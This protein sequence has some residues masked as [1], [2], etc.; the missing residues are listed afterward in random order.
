MS[1][2]TSRNLLRKRLGVEKRNTRCTTW[3]WNSGLIF[4]LDVFLD[5]SVSMCRL[6]RFQQLFCLFKWKNSTKD[7]LYIEKEM[8]RKTSRNL[9]RKRLGVEKRYTRYTTWAWNSWL[10][11]FLDVFLDTSVYSCIWTADPWDPRSGPCRDAWPASGQEPPSEGER[12]CWAG[13]GPQKWSVAL[14]AEQ[15]P[16][17]GWTIREVSFTF[18]RRGEEH[19]VSP[20]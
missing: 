20:S 9:R 19:L 12:D 14:S 16:P 8:S 10:K 6:Q 1:R 17:V 4:F 3:A 11:N 18:L 2:K 7:N 13:N 15:L 5:T